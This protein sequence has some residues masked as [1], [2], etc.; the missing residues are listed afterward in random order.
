MKR[1]A[2]PWF[3][4]AIATSML[5]VSCAA[6]PAPSAAPRPN[7]AAPAPA[8]AVAPS[9]APVAPGA[10]SAA[11]ESADS[12][13]YSADTERKIV[14][15]ATVSLVVSDAQASLDAASKMSVD[16]GGYVSDSS[17]WRQDSQLRARVTLRVPSERLNDAL[18]ILHKMSVR[19]ESENLTGQDV[20]AEYSD[21]NAQLK[22]LQATEAQLRELMVEVRQK[23]QKAEDILSVQRELTN[24]RG[25][26]E[27]LQGRINYLASATSLATIKVEFIPDVLAQPVVEP[28]WRPAETLRTA[29]RQ[30][31]SA[32]KGLANILIYVV[33]LIIPVV[34]ILA[35]PL[36][37]L[38]LLIRALAR[39]SRSKAAKAAAP[40]S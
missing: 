12:Q 36:I 2:T 22:N 25:E 6:A 23:T 27:R 16:M 17:T 24:V 26:I 37:L 8:R 35:V 20:T 38:V 34:L 11:K 18:E 33:V 7:T 10:P 30:L 19:V 39:R 40:K 13:T 14:R 15:N 1:L 3:I 21:L 4:A 32:L 29:S 5:L 31:V 9:V 28:G